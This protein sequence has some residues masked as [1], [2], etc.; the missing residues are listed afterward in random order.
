MSDLINACRDR[1]SDKVEKI[2]KHNIY[3]NPNFQN[4]DEDTALLW[5]SYWGDTE[6]L[7]LLL[8]YENY[9]EK[10]NPNLQDSNGYTSLTWACARGHIETVKLLLNYKKYSEKINP[11]LQDKNGETLLTYASY[12]NNTEILKILL[13]YTNYSE[14]INPNVYHCCGDNTAITHISCN[15]N[16]EALKLLLM[17][18]NYSEKIDPNVRACNG[19][20]ALLYASMRGYIKISNL[21]ENYI[22]FRKNIDIFIPSYNILLFILIK[23]KHMSTLP[24]EMILLI[25]E[26]GEE[27]CG[28]INAKLPYT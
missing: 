5:V 18:K 8:Q 15:N 22:L 4:K 6:M 20:T 27:I 17:C 11:N 1:H 13:Q 10:I 25:K 12:N 7:K 19:K 28:K 14:K 21:L 16:I 26:Y 2:L 9:I 23:N 24:N 3:I